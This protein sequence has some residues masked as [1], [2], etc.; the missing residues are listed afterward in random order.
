M[1]YWHRL[2]VVAGVLL[3]TAIVAKLVDRGLARRALD[4]ASATR[5]RV[6]RR[7]VVSVVVGFGLLS[8]LPVIPPAAAV[9]GRNRPPSAGAGL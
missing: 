4:P 9:R 1:P 8:A 5:F 3:V 2:L 6:L 7:T